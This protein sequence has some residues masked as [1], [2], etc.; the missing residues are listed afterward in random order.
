M[1]GVIP[2]P[3]PPPV[4]ADLETSEGLDL[5]LTPSTSVVVPFTVFTANSGSFAFTSGGAFTM[6]SNGSYNVILTFNVFNPVGTDREME[7]DPPPP[8]PDPAQLIAFMAYSGISIANT[9]T[10]LKIQPAESQTCV[11]T[12]N[13]LN[14]TA[15]TE[16]NASLQAGADTSLL[17]QDANLSVSF[18]G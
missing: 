10:F 8:S 13:I 3:P 11:V 17:L 4:R 12:T 15:G 14:Y 18:I 6:P 5:T 9:T 1:S 2:P 16:I 7:S